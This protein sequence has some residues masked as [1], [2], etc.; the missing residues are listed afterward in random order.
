[1]INQFFPFIL[2]QIHHNIKTLLL[3]PLSMQQI[4]VACDYPNLDKLI[5]KSIKPEDFL[6]YFSGKKHFFYLY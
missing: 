5:I 1:M 6:N 3:E 2:P 4:L